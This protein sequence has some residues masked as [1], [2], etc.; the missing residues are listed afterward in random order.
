MKYVLLV[1]SF[2]C[3]TTSI[4]STTISPYRDMG[5]L[6]QA[7]DA[8]YL[9]EAKQIRIDEQGSQTN[10]FHEFEVLETIKGES[11]STIPVK[12]HSVYTS[13]VYKSITGEIQFEE[14]IQYLLFLRKTNQ[15]DWITSCVSYYIFEKMTVD[16]Q[17]VLVPKY[18]T[19]LLNIAQAKTQKEPLF[20]YSKDLLIKELSAVV[21]SGKSWDNTVAKIDVD[22]QSD[23]G[24]IHKAIPSHCNL[25]PVNP[26]PRWEDMDTDPVKVYYESNI[27][28][29]SNIGSKMNYILTNMNTT[30]GGL[31][32]DLAGSFN[33]YTPDCSV[34]NSA[35]KGNF[36]NYVDNNLNGNRSIAV[37]FDDPCDQIP[38]L[39]GCNGTLAFGGFYYYSSS[40]HPYN[41]ETF[42]E[43]AYGYVVV[44]NGVGSCN[45]ESTSNGNSE[46][47][48]TL[49]LMHELTHSI[50]FF[51][52]NSSVTHANM[53]AYS[54][55][56]NSSVSSYD[57]QCV[58]YLYNPVVGEG[59]T[60]SAA[61]NYDPSATANDGS[62]TYC[63][64]NVQDGD[65]TGIDCGGSGPGCPNCVPDLEFADCGTFIATENSLAVSSIHVQNIGN[66][67]SGASYVGYYLSTNTN[68]TASD[69]LIGTD[70][71][72]SLTPNGISIESFSIAL[73]NVNVPS[74][75]YFFGVLADYNT[76][77]S[78]SNESN[79]RCYFSNPKV[80]ISLCEDGMQNGDET[81]ID[82]GGAYCDPC[83]PD[84]E[85]E[86][87]GSL[88]INSTTISLSNVRIKNY[89][90]GTS[91]FSYV[92]YYLSTN[93]VITETDYRIGTNYVNSLAPGNSSAESFSYSISNLDIP[94]GRYY[95]GMIADYS[96]SVTESSEI[97]NS[98]YH[99][100]PRLLISS[101][102][103]GI[104][105][106]DE[107]EV[108]CGGT[109]CGQCDCDSNTVYTSDI[110]KDENRHAPSWIRTSGPVTVKAIADVNFVAKDYILLNPSFE[111]RK[112]SQTVM[113]T[114][115]CKN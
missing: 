25:F 30:Y 68:I 80:V 19:G 24:K 9:V 51:H 90:N 112:G 29:C 76:Q 73:A 38:N 10:Y 106:G 77:I 104:L 26:P 36:I 27:S 100:S 34:D 63:S 64:N 102:D 95:I 91:P 45:C 78:E 32:L 114:Q 81:G 3:I 67:A 107:T 48:F 66:V 49:L 96:N 88:S 21:Q 89:G 53:S 69:Y 6:T 44:N 70:Y 46:T 79:N 35:I 17:E 37:I 72:N 61:E 1:V 43:G 101:C 84:L 85:I 71:V 31:N 39:N 18:H 92:A 22:L 60:D 11:Q 87:C 86:S 75:E 94:F 7:V 13:G 55:C 57:L 5:E 108:D 2:L 54:C 97:N 15:G 113:R 105:N 50:G 99:N 62:C 40:Q 8:I 23:H 52:M 58:D 74:G 42:S 28:S 59:C 115:G 41:G 4:Y 82:C 109:L 14:G 93:S 98:C 20:I 12:Y 83:L 56:A 103:D 47:N 33:N 16:T 110:N 65:E 111:I